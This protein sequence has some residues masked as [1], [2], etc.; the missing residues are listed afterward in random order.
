MFLEFIRKFFFL[1]YAPE[2]VK[3]MLE[4]GG[5]DIEITVLNQKIQRIAIDSVT[6]F[7]MLYENEFEMRVRKRF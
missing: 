1:S 5:G 3:T 2:K 6:N 7:V 4:E